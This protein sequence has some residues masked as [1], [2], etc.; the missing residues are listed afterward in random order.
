MITFDEIRAAFAQTEFTSRQNVT[1]NQKP[2]TLISISELKKACGYPKG[3]QFF[4]EI[5]HYCY[6]YYNDGFIF[7][8]ENDLITPRKKPVKGL[9]CYNT[10]YYVYDFENLAGDTLYIGSSS[11][12]EQRLK[13]HFQGHSNLKH[14]HQEINNWTE[15]VVVYPC[16]SKAHM[17]YMEEG[18]IATLNPYMNNISRG[19]TPPEDFDSRKWGYIHMNTY[20]NYFLNGIKSSK[21]NFKNCPTQKT[22]SINRQNMCG[23]H[24]NMDSFSMTIIY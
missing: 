14:V 16:T 24:T 6:L 11:N 12:I 17:L 22:P 3:H 7:I 13:D 18:M 10:K 5:C 21:K 20:G 9:P 2:L 1:I 19:E 4:D 23:S 15:F 8:D